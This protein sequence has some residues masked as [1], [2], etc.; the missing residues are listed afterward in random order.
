[1]AQLT[2]TDIVCV[3]CRLLLLLLLCAAAATAANKS[4]STAN[5]TRRLWKH[6]RKTYTCV[7]S[8]SLCEPRSGLFSGSISQGH[9]GGRAHMSLHAHAPPRTSYVPT[10]VLSAVGVWHQ[11]STRDNAHRASRAMRPCVL[12]QPSGLPEGSLEGGSLKQ[13]QTRC[14]RERAN[15][16][17]RYKRRGVK[18]ERKNAGYN[19]LR[20]TGMKCW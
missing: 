1:M 11:L 6:D 17:I 16:T 13:N 10:Q 8:Y 20:R 2:H 18:P 14:A 12:R 5:R 3:P 15:R 7:A 19:H 9:T 4:T